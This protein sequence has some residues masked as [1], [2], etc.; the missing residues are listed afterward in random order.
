MQLK[1][2][3][4]CEVKQLYSCLRLCNANLKPILVKTPYLETLS[5]FQKAIL[6]LKGPCII[7]WVKRVRF[8]FYFFPRGIKLDSPSSLYSNVT[9]NSLSTK[10]MSKGLTY[11]FLSCLWSKQAYV[12]RA[13]NRSSDIRDNFYNLIRGIAMKNILSFLFNIHFLC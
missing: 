3:E 11:N 5:L 9:D 1:G 13:L 2:V 8:I 6:N 10:V 4:L 7:H 12:G